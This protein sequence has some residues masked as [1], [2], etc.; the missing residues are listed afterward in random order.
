LIVGIFNLNTLT[1]ATPFY[2][3]EQGL[4]NYFE[5]LK[6][7]YQEFNK[8]IKISFLF[9]DDG[10]TD[11]TKKK[12]LE[13]KEKN[14]H[15]EIETFFHDKNYGYGRTLKNSIQLCKTTYLITYDSDCTYDYKIIGQLINNINNQK[16]DIVNVS[17][18]LSK[19][20]TNINFLRSILSWG[21]SFVYKFFFSETRSY[22]ITVFTCSFRIYKVQK[23]KNIK[24]VSEDFNS[25][26][27]LMLKAM[28]NK[29]QIYEIPG[30]NIGRKFGYSKMKI[31]KNIYN[32]LKTLFIIKYK[33]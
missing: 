32:T 8:D 19:N 18:K 15:Y 2:N 4:E 24:L 1:I 20:Q 33:I 10:S 3:E 28:I 13:F 7:I 22:K 16:N 12:L 11:S 29:L 30:E 5:T 6:K 9:I 26:A 14:L 25:C 21:G 17:Y 23:I 31:L 27:E